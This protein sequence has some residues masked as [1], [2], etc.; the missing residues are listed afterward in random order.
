MTHFLFL[1]ETYKYSIYKDQ[2]EITLTPILF[3]FLS[4]VLFSGEHL[5]ICFFFF[6]FYNLKQNF[7]TNFSP[8]VSFLF[9]ALT[10][11]I[12]QKGLGRNHSHATITLISFLSLFLLPSLSRQVKWAGNLW[13]P[14]L[15]SADLVLFLH[16]Q[17]E[18][19][20][21]PPLSCHPIPWTTL[22]QQSSPSQLTAGS[23]VQVNKSLPLPPQAWWEL[24]TSIGSAG[25][26]SGLFAWGEGF[27]ADAGDGFS[28]SSLLLASA[29]WL[30]L[31]VCRGE[32]QLVL[33][34]VPCL[35]WG[36]ERRMVGI[37]YVITPLCVVLCREDKG[38]KNGKGM[39]VRERLSV[40]TPPFCVLWCEG[41][42]WQGREG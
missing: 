39:K 41:R 13:W 9:L 40:T 33:N 19:L 22:S 35:C 25:A 16:I 2:P 8:F 3:F 32:L 11:V 24:G 10:Q 23:R 38:E 27:D 20:P 15:T 5:Y 21:W 30:L 34:L 6:P 18:A 14:F 12:Y 42:V 31:E 37:I 29:V 7:P 26:V 28:P 1:L 17:T 36:M 4:F